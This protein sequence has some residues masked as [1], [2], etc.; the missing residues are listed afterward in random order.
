MLEH[1]RGNKHKAIPKNNSIFMS[2]LHFPII[3]ILK[4]MLKYIIHKPKP[5]K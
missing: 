1:L 5:T 4:C 3:D 2:Q